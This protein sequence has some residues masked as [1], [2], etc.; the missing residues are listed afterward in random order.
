MP[1]PLTVCPC[2]GGGI[3]F[4]RGFTWINPIELLKGEPACD[5]IEAGHRHAICP[6]CNTA[7]VAGDRAGLMWVGEKYYTPESFVEESRTMGLSK[8]ISAVPLEFEFGRHW[9]LLAHKKGL[10]RM[11]IDERGQY[12]VTH[13]PAIFFAFRPS[14]VEIVIDDPNRIPARALA[15]AERLGDNA[16]LIVVEREEAIQ[17]ALVEIG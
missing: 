7:A 17:P 9:V 15:I 1:W 2:C 3:K 12:Q 6:F 8:R 11:E 14:Q 16:R 5:P 10:S 13:Q 4:A